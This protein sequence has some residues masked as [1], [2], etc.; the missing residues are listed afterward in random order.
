MNACTRMKTADMSTVL[1]W[2]RIDC[3]G[4]LGLLSDHQTNFQNSWNELDDDKGPESIN[5]TNETFI[6]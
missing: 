4:Q 2:T 3:F 1:F 6:L 5:C